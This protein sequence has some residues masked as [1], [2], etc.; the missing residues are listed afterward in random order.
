MSEELSSPIF[1]PG[2]DW[3]KR[4]RSLQRLPRVQTDGV[5][6]SALSFRAT[7]AWQPSAY[8]AA[9]TSAASAAIAAAAS[10]AYT[11]VPA[12][13]PAAAASR[14]TAWAEA[15]QPQ[16]CAF[17]GWGQRTAQI[18]LRAHCG[19]SRRSLGPDLRHKE[20]ESCESGQGW[21]RWQPC[22][23]LIVSIFIPLIVSALRTAAALHLVKAVSLYTLYC[24]RCATQPFTLGCLS[25]A[26]P[27]LT[28]RCS[29]KR[30]S[31][32]HKMGRCSNTRQKRHTK[33]HTLGWSH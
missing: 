32:G 2:I 24:A 8:S 7:Y 26:R 18:L 16:P 1:V 12:P 21:L 29:H 23:R 25:A 31:K 6:R 9:A 5:P 30:L 10:A 4:Q 19:S 20:K 11:A 22:G 15:C 13:A 27:P 17:R 14:A 28:H 33:K 3:K